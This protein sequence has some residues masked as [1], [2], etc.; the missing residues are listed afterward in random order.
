MPIEIGIWRIN[1][2]LEKINF[3]PMPNERKLETAICK[4][5]GMID[6]DL[7]LIGN[8]VMTSYLKSIDLLAINPKGEL[9]VIELKK[10][11]T[12]REVVAQILDYASWVEDLSYEDVVKL[13]A[14]K[15]K[16]QDFNQAFSERFGSDLPEHINESHR[17]IILAAELDNST[18]RII[19]YL[20]GF[21]VPVN[22]IFFRYFKYG[23]DEYL[24]RS[25]LIDPG[26]AEE[27]ASKNLSKTNKEIWNGRDWYISLG[28]SDHRNWDDCQKYGF[29][30]AGGGTWYTNT[31]KLLPIGARLF[32]CIP[33]KGYV[34]V[35]TVKEKAIPVKDFIVDVDGVE[36]PILD[37]PL[38]AK[39]MGEFADDL[40]NSEYLVRVEWKKT[41]PINHAVWE[42]GM[43]ANQ[44]SACKL[45]NNF[46]IERL[47]EIFELNEE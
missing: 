39:K 42:K 11:Q 4:D 37:A 46:T 44:N 45:R 19:N 35:A 36:M 23:S 16:G 3:S 9:V 2:T 33:Q 25:W 28:V 12:P 7:M 5:I 1:D 8:Q 17:L 22:A 21:G 47:T 13:Y 18:E 41:I 29:I 24:A 15:N 20:V 40:E 43:F 26:Q 31:L 30:S 32:V 6:P 27:K 38:K 34:G 10:N 14:E